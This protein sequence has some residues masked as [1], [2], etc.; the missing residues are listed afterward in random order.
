MRLTV[1]AVTDLSEIVVLVS[2]LAFLVIG[3]KWSLE[4][5]VL[6]AESSNNKKNVQIEDVEADI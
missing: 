3:A 2:T 4:G 1:L 6:I 5:V